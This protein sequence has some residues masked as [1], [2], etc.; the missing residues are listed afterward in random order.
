MV[1]FPHTA[2]GDATVLARG[3]NGFLRR[4]EDGA[5]VIATRIIL[6]PTFAETFDTRRCD[7]PQRCRKQ[8]ARQPLIVPDKSRDD[9]PR[10]G[11]GS[12]SACPPIISDSRHFETNL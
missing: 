1:D 10:A 5:G 12:Q 2:G 9:L 11:G 8:P 7:A 3:D 6:R 4:V